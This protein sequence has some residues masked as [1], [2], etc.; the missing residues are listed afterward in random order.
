[1]AVGRTETK[2]FGLWYVAVPPLTINF[3]ISSGRYSEEIMIHMEQ[4]GVTN[5]SESNLP[6]EH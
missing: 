3:L 6:E 1:M 5:Q 2:T 4:A